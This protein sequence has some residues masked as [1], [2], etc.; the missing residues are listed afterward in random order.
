MTGGLNAFGSSDANRLSV[1]RTRFA[2]LDR[3]ETTL[4]HRGSADA[5][6]MTV[7]STLDLS[8]VVRPC[9]G[10]SGEGLDPVTGP[11]VSVRAGEKIPG[12][13]RAGFGGGGAT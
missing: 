12:R 4:A 11:V 13:S 8:G 9:P 3:D 1:N 2:C 6:A 5:S 7:P 10:S